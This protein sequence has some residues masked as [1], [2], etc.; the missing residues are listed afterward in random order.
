MTPGWWE[1]LLLGLVQGLTEFLPVSSS[2][3]LVIAESLLGLSAPGVLFEVVLHL[4]TL[5][6]VL[7]AYRGRLI[8]LGRG[9]FTGEWES[10]RYAGLLLL[11]SLP[12]AVAGLGFRDF[13]E[14]R[15]ETGLWLGVFFLLTTA[16]LWTTR[17]ALPRAAETRIGVGAALFI[18]LAQALAILPAVSRSGTTIAA[19]LWAGIAP[20]PAAEFS[21]LLSIIAIAG[22]G[23]IQ[24]LD[25]PVGV[26]LAAPGVLIG[27]AVAV[28]T[29]V[30]AIRFLVRLLSRGRFHQFAWYTAAVGS[31]TFLW[32]LVAGS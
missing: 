12:A 28:A 24:L 3:H 32:A 10:W 14:A 18:G 19:A 20:G 31:V 26:D 1:G 9:V 25:M 2:G 5:L 16:I 6:A 30:W 27:F 23:F 4:A 13:F 29:G 22:A 8:R 15:F 17:F 7:I 21:F 11:G